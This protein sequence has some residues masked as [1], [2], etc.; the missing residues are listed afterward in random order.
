[1]A[2]SHVLRGD[3][4]LTNTPKQ[5]MVFDAMSWPLPQYG[6]MTLIVNPEGK[7]L[8]KRDGSI[9]QFIEQ[10][11]RAGYLP[12]ALFNFIALLGFSPEGEEEIFDKE[13]FIER[14]DTKRLSTSP[15]T[16][17]VQKLRYL[18]H[19]Y[20]QKL[21]L[22][23]LSALC[24][25]YIKEH[26]LGRYEDAQWIN[27]LC[28]VFQER[29]EYAS[30]ITEH[31]HAF[32]EHPFRLEEEHLTFLN[33]ENAQPILQAFQA[34]LEALTLFEP[35]TL[36]GLIKEV[37]QATEAK[38]KRLFMSLRL[39]VSA[40]MHGPELPKMMHLMGKERVQ[41]RIEETLKHLN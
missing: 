19:H 34:G 18:N 8:S 4:H 17:D 22:E 30:Q 11:D 10:Y 35:E 32:F 31:Y 24:E 39:A 7:K 33:E 40:S 9:M 16:F 2:I 25:P 27:S 26:Q 36:K 6:H 38:G 3:D 41:Q 15:A 13:G 14:F 28:A 23:T 29:L 21:P 5:L 20:L 37:G 1:M 12:E